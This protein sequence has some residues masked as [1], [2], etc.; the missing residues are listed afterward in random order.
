V[1]QSLLA[2][3]NLAVVLHEL[4]VLPSPSTLELERETAFQVPIL[5]NV[6]KIFVYKYL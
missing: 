6:K 5:L 2:S 3:Q 4:G 1:V